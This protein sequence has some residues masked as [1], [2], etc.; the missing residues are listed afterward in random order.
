MRNYL[1]YLVM[2]VMGLAC[3]VHTSAQQAFTPPSE[4]VV[5]VKL[6]REVAARISQAPLPMSNGVVTTGIKPLDR[7]NSQAKAVSIKRCIP[8]SP[9]YEARH[10]AAGLDL[11]YE[12]KFDP[13]AM[14]PASA[15]NLYKS[16]PGIQLVEE[17]RP[18]K[19]IGDGPARVV[20]MPKAA[21]TAKAE[22][23]FNDPMLSQQWHYNN[24]GSLTGSMPGADINANAAWDIETGN[25]DVLVAIIDGAFQTDHPDLKDNVWVN[26]A[27]LNGKP[28]VDDDGNGYVDDV[29]G[30]NFVCDSN[31][32]YPHQH[33]T[34]VAGTVGATNNNGIGV[35]GVAG[36]SDGHGGV[37]M[38][39]CQVF[40]SRSSLNADFGSALVYAADNGAS[41]AQCSWGWD[42]SGYYEQYVLDC[43]DYFTE[44]GGGGT[45]VS[46]G[47]TEEDTSDDVWDRSNAKMLGGLCIF[48]NG[49]TGTTGTFYPAAYEP[50]VAV[51]AMDPMLNP[52]AYSSNGTFCD[53]TAPGGNVDYGTAYGVL[54][55]LPNGQ[56][57]TMDGTSMACPHVS[58]I[59]ALVLSKYGNPNFPNSTLRD[60]LVSSVNDFYTRNPEV[61]GLFGS[62]YIDAYKALQMGS[63][64]APDAVAGYTLTPS[65][66]N[67]LIEWTIPDADVKS[68]DHHNIYYSTQPFTTIEGATD[69]KQVSVD[70]KFM[71]SG[72][73]MQ[74]TLEGL[75]PVTT[76]YI[77][78]QAVSRYG[79]KSALSEVKSFT[80]NEGPKVDFSKTTLTLDVDAEQGGI[81]KDEFSINNT[82]K[83][84]LEYSLSAN[85]VSVPKPMMSNAAPSPGRVVTSGKKI[86]AYSAVSD[87]PVVSAEY[88]ADDY[89]KEMSWSNGIFYNVGDDNAKST[90]ALAQYF[91][92]DPNAYPDGFNLT[93]LRF[94]G[95][96]DSN[97]PEIEIY[98]GSQS[99]STASLLTKVNYSY[100]AYNYDINLEEQLFFEPGSSFWVVAKYPAGQTTPLGAGFTST[101][102]I[103]HYSFYSGDNGQTW[104]QLSE[105]LREGNLAQDADSLTWDVYA[106]SKNPDWSSVLSPEPISGTVRPSSSQVVTM[107]NDGQKMVN[108]NYTFNLN[109]NTNETENPKQKLTVNMKVSGN[110][111]ELSAAKVVDFGELL[112]GK[113]KTLAVE[114]VNNGYGD[115]TGKWGALQFPGNGMESSSTE[116]EPESYIAGFAARSKGKLNVTFK[117]ASAGSK[118]GTITLTDANGIKFNIVVRG[119]ASMPAEVKVDKEAIDFGY[120][121]V[122][123]EAQTDKI[124]IE[125]TGEYPLE[126]VFPRFSDET[127]DGVEAHKFGYSYESN[128]NGSK[129]FQYDGNPELANETDITS[130]FNDNVWQSQAVDLGFQFPFYGTNYSQIHINTRGGIAM[131]TIDGNIQTMIPT[132]EDVAGL[133]YVSAYACSG[134][135]HI[136]ANTKISYGRQDGKFTIKYKDV[137]APVYGDEYTPISFHMS[138]VADGSIEVYY[139]D[140]DRMNTFNEGADVFIGV[141][142]IECDDPFVVT[143]NNASYESTLYQQIT[144]GS[145]IRILAPATSMVSELSSASGVIGV[146]EKKEITITAKAVEGMY[147]GKLTNNLTILTND[148]VTPSKNVVLT[149]N[150]TGDGLVPVVKLDAEAVDFGEVFRTSTARR[151]VLLSNNGTNDLTVTAVT[152]DGGKVTV[153]ED[154]AKGFTVKPGY[155]KDIFITL[156]T[157]TEGPVTDNVRIKYQDGT[158]SVVAVS[159]TVIGCPEIAV[160]PD[161]LTLTTNCGTDIAQTLTVNNAGNEPLTFSIEPN[162]W[163]D[164]ADL[165]TENAGDIGYQYKSKTDDDNVVYDWVDIT[166]DP[167]A[168]HQDFTYYLD[169]TDY[170]TVELPF[171]FPFYGKKYKTMYIYNVGFVSFTQHEDYKEFPTP[172]TELPTDGTFYTNIIAPFWGNHTMDVSTKNGTFY[173]AE[174]DHV[175]VSFIGYGN[176]MMLG[177]DFQV[178]LYKDGSYK[179]QYHLQDGGVMIG[180]FGL[181]GAQD[182]SGEIGFQLPEQCITTGNAVEIQPVR[183]FTVPAGGKVE[184]PIEILA[185]SLGGEYATEIAIQTN[186]PTNQRVTVPVQLTIN[187]APDPVIPGKIENEAVVGSQIYT[188]YLETSFQIANAG[189]KAFK[190]TNID[191]PLD[192]MTEP[193]QLF[194]WD[195]TVK[196][197]GGMDPGPLSADA[198]ERPGQQT[199][200]NPGTV[201]EVGREP[202]NFVIWMYDNYD[203]AGELMPWELNK[204]MT[205]TLEGV[206]GMTEVKVPVEIKWTEAP[207]LTLTPA[208]GVTVNV[209]N[210]TAVTEGTMKFSNV[211]KYKMTYSLRMDPTGIGETLPTPDLGGGDPGIAMLPGNVAELGK[212][213]FMSLF[214]RTAEAIKPHTVFEGFPYDVPSYDCNNLLYYPILDVASPQTYM[215]GAGD[216]VNNFYAATR[217][218]APAEGFNMSKLYFYGTIGDMQNVDFE[219]YVV[220]GGNIAEGQVIGQGKLRVEKEEPYVDEG[221]GQATYMGEPR[222]LD[223]DKAVYINP[224]DTFYVVLKYP[225]GENSMAYVPH[226]EDAMEEGRFMAYNAQTG[227]YDLG[228]MMYE[229]YYSSFGYFMTC[230][231]DEP[232]KPWIKLL[233]GTTEGTLEV[234]QEKEVKFQLDPSSAYFERDNKAVIVIKTNDPE[235]PLVNYPVTLNRNAAPSIT[236]PEGTL[237]VPETQTAE[238][239]VA[240]EDAEGELFIVNI[241]DESGIASITEGT[242]TAAD[243]TTQPAEIADQSIAVPAGMKLDMTV[244]LAP[245]YGTAGQHTVKISAMDL[246]FNE[247][248]VNAIYNV[249]FTNRAPVY[250]GD[251]E[252][253]VYVGQTTGVI[254]YETV[255]TDPDGDQMTFSAEMADNSAASIF[256]SEAGFILSGNAVGDALLTLT[257]TDANGGKTVQEV[258]VSVVPATGIGSVEAGS[259]ISVSPNPV[260]DRL[261]VVLGEAADNVNYYVYDNAGSMVATARADHKAAGEAQT[262]DMGACAPGVYRVKVTADGKQYNA[263]VLKK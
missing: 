12:I 74:Y 213:Q 9:K 253:T 2:L 112:V 122:G 24:D 234:G 139:D 26:E 172:P 28:G 243:G 188:G 45:L 101:S 248:T 103:R 87:Y 165:E 35:S 53:V 50:C 56:Y 91:Y 136:G 55:T 207:S 39:V 143:D 52:A 5:R 231:E 86:S 157:K 21:G 107:Q 25:K 215:I 78:I 79:Y 257:A 260:V 81:G 62:G 195:T 4:G 193:A 49:N 66:D 13:K 180:V 41:I 249:E 216:D 68:V 184:V 210:S 93:A 117:P 90:N 168:A 153:A 187:G 228:Q 46:D 73:A 177:M 109:V 135:L 92:V 170:Y 164:L 140:Y 161:A 111:P 59:A 178:I 148:P 192:M 96:G 97:T 60:Q 176:S 208:D 174:D 256:T 158:E 240:V 152:V 71:T 146:G 217:Y 166:N 127:I 229:S 133:G 128:L 238:M 206:E 142:D 104:T 57:G 131:Q 198:E 72:D 69:L 214:S 43:I 134:P 221:T 98:N 22:P 132:A 32:I 76:Y 233:D 118:S 8:Y 185:D 88:M 218:T 203:M 241:D 38:M 89:P 42:Q 227:W 54:S 17:I 155:G 235:N 23:F 7:A 114:I 137:L 125:N 173:K 95:P 77:A 110:K 259:G 33:G 82:G 70:T 236:L 61:E 200:Y 237:T 113:E 75:Q 239:H 29:Y 40:D 242:L 252:M 100:F 220:Q 51:A 94:G 196:D 34:H 130:Q 204:T 80:T 144:T 123:G 254:A 58:G 14:T 209:K 156:P 258:Q 222:M 30:W 141:A 197:E 63:G 160:S 186:V 6:Q 115:F 37:T 183:M 16:V 159:G 129:A 116:F 120:L 230:V 202:V 205:V 219:A 247:R 149:A 250:E 3:G 138:L 84:I 226:K 251:E 246:S 44:Y 36:G 10:K 223:L 212:E 189:T 232:G 224:N 65:Q 201:I 151:S 199:I 245:G 154:I 163:F 194:Y 31:D 190:I 11:W 48:A 225:A 255:F 99:I 20:D 83:G 1:L 169:K 145:A 191:L 261:N 150:I 262:I 105:V 179:F 147:A 211:G 19:L 27:E 108:G 162:D 85:T 102:N 124:V 167:E 15:R 181:A 106:I 121:E 47:G 171:E 175:I 263:S 64:E 119:V 67:V 126:Y 244:K 18:M 182:E